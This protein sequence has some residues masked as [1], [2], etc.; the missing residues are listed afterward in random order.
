MRIKPLDSALSDLE[1]IAIYYQRVGGNAL[2]SKM[3]KRIRQPINNLKMHPY[4]GTPYNRVLRRLV[5]A[6]GLFLVF[7]RIEQDIIQVVHI[8]RAEQDLI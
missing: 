1:G 6:D 5:V 3:V 7:Y 2:A 4:L 8:R